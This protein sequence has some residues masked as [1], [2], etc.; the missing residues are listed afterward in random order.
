VEVVGPGNQSLGFARVEGTG[1]IAARM[2]AKAGAE[3]GDD[4]QEVSLRVK[5][6]V[7]HRR[8]LTRRGT[9]LRSV[10]GRPYTDAL[11]LIHGEADG[12]PG[13]AV[14]RLGTVLRV[15]VSGR[16]CAALASA[17]IEAVQ[18]EPWPGGPGEVIE[19]V[20][21]PAGERP[22][23]AL[24]AWHADPDPAW[25]E[26]NL[27]ARGRLRVHERGLRFQVDPGL[28]EPRRPRPGVGLFLDQRENREALATVAEGGHW[29][30]LFA[31]TGAFSVAL[32]AAGA[33][34]V[35]SVDLSGPYL[36]WLG[37]HLALNADLG[38]ESARHHSVRH[39]GRRYLAGLNRRERFDGIVLDP[40]TAAAAGRRFWSVQRDLEPLVIEALGRLK[41]GGRLLVCR[42]WRRARGSVSD[43]VEGAAKRA[44]VRLEAVE[45]AGPGADFPRRRAFPEGDSFRGVLV[46]VR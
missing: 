30:N 15:L 35:T 5:R 38:V 29:L 18:A 41:S 1:P 9:S 14:D 45:D 31:H 4:A 17:V 46:R 6:A 16:A 11:R 34:R 23:G 20:H 12:L 44:G 39:D 37:D 36:A 43:L 24:V 8:G 33:R 25:L 21:L 22:P 42:N 10:D 2:W 27:D 7:A 13:L 3:T 26:E 19:V 32:L 40:P 28:G